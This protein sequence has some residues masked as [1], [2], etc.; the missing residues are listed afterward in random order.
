M[1]EFKGQKTYRVGS[2]WEGPGWLCSWSE[3]TPHPSPGEQ[4]ILETVFLE[5]YKKNSAPYVLNH[6]S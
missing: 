2:V 4:A 1:I 6:V 3:S 5:V